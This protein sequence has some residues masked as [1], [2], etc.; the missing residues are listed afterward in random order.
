MRPVRVSLPHTT[1][2]AFFRYMPAIRTVTRINAVHLISHTLTP[3]KKILPCFSRY[4]RLAHSQ[5]R[6]LLYT[7]AMFQQ[8][9]RAFLADPK[10]PWES[11]RVLRRL[12][13]SALK[14]SIILTTCA[15]ALFKTNIHISHTL[16]WLLT[17]RKC[18]MS[19]H[20]RVLWTPHYYLLLSHLTIDYYWLLV[21]F[22][23]NTVLFYLGLTCVVL[24]GCCG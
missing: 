11:N 10:D 23:Y 20:V 3:V 6:A 9:P 18:I 16:P 5:T 19:Q 21:V 7:S 4:G 13:L 1:T 24:K 2:R 14:P 15:H 8:H 17:F 12:A 22:N